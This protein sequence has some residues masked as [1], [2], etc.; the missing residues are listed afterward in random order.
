MLVITSSLSIRVI[1]STQTRVSL[2]PQSPL[3]IAIR[4]G[5]G[6]EGGRRE[7]ERE[8]RKDGGPP[9]VHAP[10]VRSTGRLFTGAVESLLPPTSPSQNPLSLGKM[11]LSNQSLWGSLLHPGVVSSQLES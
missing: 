9:S 6:K 2:K 7:E 3:E 8:G 4:E 1:N 10:G 5:E 11:Q